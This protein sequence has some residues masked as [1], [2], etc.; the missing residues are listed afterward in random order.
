MQLLD[1]SGPIRQQILRASPGEHLPAD[2]QLVL[3]GPVEQQFLG[4]N[5]REHLEHDVPQRA[6]PPAQPVRRPDSGAAGQP[7]TASLVQRRGQ[8]AVRSYPGHFAALSGRQL[9]G[10]P[11]ALWGAAGQEVQEEVPAADT[12]LAHPDSAEAAQNQRC[13]PYRSGGWVRGRVRA[14][15]LLPAL[16]RFLREAP[17]PRL[18]YMTHL[19]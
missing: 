4:R 5:P 7:F 15:L 2:P 17:C 8:L 13:V 14:G 11:G 19:F 10:Q 3:S 16:V 12:H 1:C 9:H 6:G 18:P